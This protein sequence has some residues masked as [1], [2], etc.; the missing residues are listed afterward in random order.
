MVVN[1]YPFGAEVLLTRLF[2]DTA[3]E[4]VEPDTVLLFVEAPDH[5]VLTIGDE[6]HPLVPTGTGNYTV[7]VEASQAGTWFWRWDA[8]GNDVMDGVEEGYFVVRSSL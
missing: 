8:Q 2:L 4:P 1:T 5:T 7:T 3:G 6:A